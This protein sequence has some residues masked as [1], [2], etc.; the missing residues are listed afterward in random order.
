MRREGRNL[1]LYGASHWASD[2]LA[3]PEKFL[4][5][6]IKDSELSLDFLR[7]RRVVLDFLYEGQD[8]SL[9]KPLIDCMSGLKITG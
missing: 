8:P 4:R 6:D 3:D 1:L 2:R 9:I 5:E 7:G